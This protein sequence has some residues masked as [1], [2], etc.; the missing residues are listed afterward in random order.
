MRAQATAMR[1][2]GVVSVRHSG[3]DAQHRARNLI[4]PP[5]YVPNGFLAVRE[6]WNDG[7]HAKWRTIA[8]PANRPAIDSATEPST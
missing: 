7:D 5:A 4:S 3:G 1:G 6:P 2:C 8:N